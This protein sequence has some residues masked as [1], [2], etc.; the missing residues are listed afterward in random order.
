VIVIPAIDLLG[1]HVV[2]LVEGRREQATVY[3]D[4]PGEVARRFV[5]GGATRLHV[6]DLDGAFAGRPVNRAAIDAILAAG[7]PVQ[8]GGGLRDYAACEAA[9]VAGARFIVLGSA[10]TRDPDLFE[11]ACATLPVIAAVDARDGKVA[12][13]G[14]TEQTAADAFEVAREAVEH[15]GAAGVL[16]TDITRD[17]KRVGPN[18]EASA[19]LARALAPAEVIASGGVGTLDHLRALAAAGV[20]ACVVGRA[21][22]EGVF[23]VEEA[24]VATAVAPC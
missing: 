6:V 3:S 23:T 22:Y 7:V 5:D 24:I 19:Q 1:G 11:R 9:I 8:V 2:R 14:W 10:V 13:A 4:R 17:G 16:Y 15:Y 18:V 12:V 20:P 21:L